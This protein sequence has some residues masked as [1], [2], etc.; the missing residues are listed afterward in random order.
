MCMWTGV[1]MINWLQ[2]S[3]ERGSGSGYQAVT[4]FISLQIEPM[5]LVLVRLN[6]VQGWGKPSV[7]KHSIKWECTDCRNTFWMV[8]IDVCE[9]EQWYSKNWTFQRGWQLIGRGQQEYYYLPSLPSIRKGP[10][11]WCNSG[12][13]RELCWILLYVF[14]PL[15]P[16]SLA[17]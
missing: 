6:L 5:V 14:L 4:L 2:G 8:M 17:N 15:V 11:P 1:G 16:A 12:G 3:R 13:Q 9:K 7:C 10:I